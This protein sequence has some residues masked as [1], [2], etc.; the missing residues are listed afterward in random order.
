MGQ[1]Y[2]IDPNYQLPLV[3]VNIKNSESGFHLDNGGGFWTQGVRIPF[4]GS[5][6]KLQNATFD[7]A[8][9]T[10]QFHANY[11][12]DFG[13]NIDIAELIDAN[14]QGIAYSKQNDGSI[15]LVIRAK[16]GDFKVSDF[17]I[18]PDGR[19]K[20][21][22]I[23]Y[24]WLHYNAVVAMDPNPEQAI[25]NT[26]AAIEKEG[27]ILPNTNQLIGI[28]K[29]NP[30]VVGETT[31]SFYNEQN[32][33]QN[34]PAYVQQ[35]ADAVKK[36][37]MEGQTT[38]NIHYINGLAGAE[39][40]SVESHVGWPDNN[41]QGHMA[42]HLSINEKSVYGYHYRTTNDNKY[43]NDQGTDDQNSGSHTGIISENGYQILVNGQ[44]TKLTY[45]Q[46][47]VQDY[48]LILDPDPQKIIV[49][50]V[51]EDENNKLI[52]TDTLNGYSD[53]KANYN[54]NGHIPS[55]YEV[56]KNITDIN[57]LNSLVF[58]ENDQ[59]AQ[60]YTIVLKHIHHKNSETKT[61]NR[62]VN[63]ISPDE[64]KT[65]TNN[66][67][68][69]TR[70]ADV[71]DV[72]GQTQYSGWTNGD[73]G[74]FNEVT[75]PAIAGYT[76]QSD[77]TEDL[78]KNAKG[79]YEIKS[80]HVDQDSNDIVVNVTYGADAQKATITYIDDDETNS[81]GKQGKVINVQ[82]LS[83]HTAE[84][85]ST[86]VQ[87][88]IDNY[89]KAGY[90]LDS[91]DAPDQLTFDNEDH[92]TQA[93]TVHLGHGHITVTPDQPKEPGDNIPDTNKH[94]PKGVDHDSLNK[95]V[96]RTV[97]ITDPNNKKNQIV[98]IITFTRTADV[99][100]V[101]GNFTYG[102]WPNND[103]G[104]FNAVNIP[105]FAGYTPQS[106]PAA[107]LEADSQGQNKVKAFAVNHTSGDI[108][109]NVTYGADAQ[110]ATITYIDDDETN[111]D[112][113]QGKVINVQNLSGHTAE[114]I[115]TNVQTAIDNYKKAGYVLDSNDAPDQ[116]T[117]DNEDHTTQ[118]FTVH[119]G[120]G[121]I[122][123]DPNNSKTPSDVIPGTD[124][125]FPKG[126]DHDSLNKTV[127]RTINVTD[128]NGNKN[129]KVDQIT[130]T[131][132]AEVDEVTGDV[133]YSDWTNGNNGDTGEFDETVITS[134]YGYT[135]HADYLGKNSKGQYVINEISVSHKSNN[136]VINVTYTADPQ[137]ANLNFVDDEGHVDLAKWDT[138][139]GFSNGPIS[140]SH[141]EEILKE[142]L[143]QGYQFVNV[144]N[145]TDNADHKVVSG[146][147]FEE[148]AKKFGEFDVLDNVD[149]IFTVHLKHS[150]VTVNPNDPKNPNDPIPGTDKHFPNGVDHDSLY[151]TITRTV[152]VTD[153]I[154]K[155]TKTTS[156]SVTLT[157]SA[158]VDVVTGDV[159]YGKW[160]ASKF[161]GQTIDP[162]KG[163]TSHIK[164]HEN[165]H[166]ED[167][168]SIT[169]EKVTSE[170]PNEVFD[171]TYSADPQ[172]ATI[173][174][175]DDDSH[176][177]LHVDKFDGVTNGTV[178]TNVQKTI[179]AYQKAGYVV[180]N[181]NAPADITFDNDDDT[182]QAFTVHLKHNHVTVNP[183][184][185]KTPSDV[186]PGTD[187]HFPNGVNHDSLYKTITRTVNVTD[188]I[189]K[190]TKTT[191]QSVTLTRSADVDVVTGHVTYGNWSTGNFRSQKLNPIQGYTMHI[192][193]HENNE[194]M[195]ADNIPDEKVT[196]ETS[197]EV[198]DVTYSADQQKAHLHF[199]DDDLNRTLDKSDDQT[200]VSDQGP[201]SFNHAADI[202]NGYLKQGYQFSEVT[203]D[204]DEKNHKAVPGQNFADAMSH[205]GNFDRLDDVDQFF[206]VHLKHG[207]VTVDPKNPKTPSDIIPGTD[208]HFPKDVDHDSLNKTI[209][210][211][212]NV[213]YPISNET[214]TTSQSVILTRSAD[215]DVVTRNATYGKWST[216][217]F[218]GQTVASIK[219]YTSHIKLHENDHDEDVNNIPD[220]TVNEKTP[221][222]VFDVTYSADPQHATIT[223]YDDDTH[224][225]LHVDK[226]D[227]VT[228]ETIHT[229]VQKTIDA[230]Q[231]AGYVVANNNAP[232][233]I[234]FDNNDETDQT[235][236]VHLKHNHVT[237]DPKNPKT[238][239][240]V[241]PGTDNHFPKG[242]DHDDL[243]RTITRTIIVN[244]PDGHHQTITQ[245]ATFTR[246]ATVDEVTRKVTYGEWN[247]ASQKLS[248]FDA[249]VI[250]G[251]VPN[252]KFV[253]EI[254]V[255]PDSKDTTVEIYYQVD[256]AIERTHRQRLV[257]SNA[258]SSSTS[259]RDGQHYSNNDW[260]NAHSN[261]QRLPQ[262]GND[263][264]E[265][266]IGLGLV[267]TMMSMLGLADKK[268]R[269][270]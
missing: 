57:I 65:Q 224:Q 69:F 111:S 28:D 215:V 15:N 144:T 121:H 8:D 231:K 230:Y 48:D 247:V 124:K 206:T 73:N 253:P 50:Y 234:T 202:L 229:N 190:E 238:P 90:V 251:Y 232:A 17:G 212:V 101:T 265:A 264:S 129:R 140:F 53:M 123:V 13:N 62:T 163:Y 86:N 241:I 187:K 125:H 169:D 103:Q 14:Y 74:T 170:T 131:R 201:I 185:P 176:T 109:V 106:D 141:A 220:E 107:D 168:K 110:K 196:S 188:P 60:T 80:F 191:S 249:P 71:D 167:V 143:Q 146:N 137:V 122:S 132:T 207:H 5:D 257:D 153:P 35:T 10:T 89:K 9:I 54:V 228:N 255:N 184:N 6:G 269:H 200:G 268:R 66:Q 98:N 40:K 1:N 112:G 225:S 134:F 209:T 115:S 39:I 171:V 133:H 152:N 186:I 85:I 267:G 118:A 155:E 182:D 44:S 116:L 250:N 11:T 127:T 219:G 160:S 218:N 36:F 217:K 148:A 175:Y 82:N 192:A 252:I 213:T 52:Q 76:P 149:Q 33:D 41:K 226:F 81:D 193:L 38:I 16:A 262:T 58:N 156:Q 154:S 108:T 159:T 177:S 105:T 263:H 18:N 63:I 30:S 91:N 203:D 61:V 114:T 135:P 210:R 197:N 198:F 248:Q 266:L 97:N 256:P 260:N 12:K 216:D 223:Y 161:N 128:P 94:F 96:T 84:T 95:T 194:D 172:H 120:H 78:E 19:F 72:T 4:Y 245:T 3:A 244:Y 87:T 55:H 240:D 142:Y 211:T 37:A 183:K 174:Y 166:D 64:T 102:G 259:L 104:T 270:L 2:K 67:I 70:T 77:I 233:D 205:L 31:T 119:L 130:F 221:N 214:K 150:H 29:D 93:F 162:I 181:N 68:T 32:K 189:T 47:G 24:N 26:I 243:N 136:I 27:S 165:D 113:K 83:G 208:K 49:N 195:A 242:V 56:D 222:E 20:Q 117:F 100:E 157:R 23:A 158:D 21:G 258:I 151:K 227:G 254:T 138:Q 34:H 25:R 88:A 145:D 164:L 99:D 179:D 79:Q 7:G 75:I 59:K 22:G 46:N 236:T 147:S 45:P 139:S 92:T 239:S 180:A 51:D 261:A 43:L 204:T 42:D 246:N 199:V 173:T 178:Q 235:F 126:V 237:V